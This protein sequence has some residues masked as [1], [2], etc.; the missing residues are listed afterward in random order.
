MDENKESLDNTDEIPKTGEEK[1]QANLRPPWEPGCPPPNPNGR[2]KG[3]ISLVS[4]MRKLAAAEA[5]GEDAA[6]D[7]IREIY[8]EEIAEKI[9]NAHIYI[10]RVHQ[11]AIKG[12]EWA[13]KVWLNYIDGMPRQSLDL[14]GQKDN[15]LYGKYDFNTLPVEELR[16]LKDMLSKAKTKDNDAKRD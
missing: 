12:E 1:R 13:I 11:A 7:K 3:A 9:T 2:P 8:G 14:G 6:R 16:E 10:A 15:P 4:L 5:K